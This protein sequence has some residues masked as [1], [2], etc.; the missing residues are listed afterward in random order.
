MIYETGE[1]RTMYDMQASWE[2]EENVLRI[3]PHWDR[4]DGFGL[5]SS[6]FFTS[7]YGIG[8]SDMRI[9]SHEHAERA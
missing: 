4:V 6:L 8:F 5:L 3:L 2:V 9:C 1:P 7:H